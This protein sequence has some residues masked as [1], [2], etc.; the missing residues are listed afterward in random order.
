MIATDE[1]ISQVE[2]HD[3][4]I[5]M[6]ENAKEAGMTEERFKRYQ[7]IAAEAHLEA[8]RQVDL[9]IK[10]QQDRETKSWWKDEKAKTRGVVTSVIDA[11]PS[12]RASQFF[13]DGTIPPDVEDSSGILYQEGSPVKLSASALDN[14][15]GTQAAAIK[16][17][18]G[19][20]A[21]VKVGGVHPDEVAS[22][23]QFKSGDEMV[24]AMVNEP[25]R[26][27]QIAE[28]TK[29]RMVAAHGDIMKDGTIEFVSRE[30]VHDSAGH[31][32]MLQTE[33]DSMN[34]QAGQPV[35]KLSKT[36]LSGYAETQILG[37]TVRQ[38][39]PNRYLQSE[40]KAAT[41]AQRATRKGKFD[42]A[43]QWQKKRM[44]NR[45]LYSAAMEARKKAE[46]GIKFLARQNRDDARRALGLMDTVDPQ[47]NQVT[48]SYLQQQDK[49]L[50]R[51][52]LRKVSA[53]TVK[54]RQSLAEWIQR[55]TEANRDPVVPQNLLD[56][57]QRMNYADM[58]LADFLDLVDTVKNIKKQSDRKRRLKVGAEEVMFDA[59]VE[60]G[61]AQ[62]AVNGGSSEPTRVSRQNRTWA[63][64][65]I[66][67]PIRG[68]D[69]ELVRLREVANQLDGDDP[70]GLFHRIL[71]HPL[72][73]A[74]V[75]E[76]EMNVKV[77]ALILKALQELSPVERAL[78][79]SMDTIKIPSI[80]DS[81][82]MS[83][84]ITVGLQSGN[85]GNEF[86]LLAG[87]Q[88]N[89]QG[90]TP[91]TVDTLSEM[92]SQL[93]EEHWDLIQKIWDA[94]ET[95]WP[96]ASALEKRMTGLDPKK[97]EAKGFSITLPDGTTK[98]Y[99]GGYYPII[100]DPLFSG[101]NLQAPVGVGG[102]LY[103]K[104]QVR[105]VTPN[106][107]L[108]DRIDN[109]ARPIS[110]RLDGMVSHITSVIHDTTHRES[111]ISAWRFMA[112]QRI[113]DAMIRHMGE[114]YYRMVLERLR[115]VAQARNQPSKFLNIMHRGTAA[116]SAS[117][118]GFKMS[119]SLQNIANFVL[120]KQAVGTVPLA[121]AMVQYAG[122]PIQMTKTIT[123]L[124]GV[125]RH[126]MQ[127]RDNELRQAYQVMLGLDT[128][129]RKRAQHEVVK[130]GYRFM[131]MTNAIS[132]FPTW[133]AAFQSASKTMTEQEAVRAAD[134][135]IISTFGGGNVKDLALVQDNEI[136]KPF[137][138]FYGFFSSV[139]N[140]T[141]RAGRISAKQWRSGQKG[142][143][144]AG[145]LEYVLWN[146]V[147]MNAMSELF[148][149]RGPDDDPEDDPKD[150]MKTWAAWS[151][152]KGASYTFAMVPFVRDIYRMA[153]SGRREASLTPLTSIATEV[154]R[155]AQAVGKAG[156]DL[157]DADEIDSEMLAELGGNIG[158]GAL[159][160]WAIYEGMP[161][162]QFNI[163]TGFLWDWLVNENSPENWSEGVHDL[164]FTKRRNK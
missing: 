144:V 38:V 14:M 111:L 74:A 163:T 127:N 160:S 43:V 100:Y 32:K 19:D 134:D 139:Y 97:V 52:E 23:F 58:K 164:L 68:L 57:S 130:M 94:L 99:R 39:D 85:V 40:R 77:T 110:L 157:W 88:T 16:R 22:A 124:S 150:R 12:V 118:M 3:Q 60:E 149:G 126:R 151:M 142:K 84:L 37:A 75:S 125:M 154:G 6:F 78:L 153:E 54:A 45:Y 103:S 145:S 79:G 50:E 107:H 64:R 26:A 71:I 162:S 83:D 36:V 108:Q 34:R 9:Q 112:D 120:A 138:M 93:G 59:F 47:T 98:A 148:S 140:M 81:V 147:V 132:E 70:N 114:E 146:I 42:E 7:E 28:E 62:I 82:L 159:K 35:V 133:L 2:N 1:Q 72:D 65:A 104:D 129:R 95:L 156:I 69:A 123:A 117:M 109:Y 128:T 17:R 61:A 5:P 136:M 31:L 10:M 20:K 121:Q 152:A 116:V 76:S 113:A 80:G 102:T 24:R 18:L 56:E 29:R 15:Y 90:V 13:R 41:E 49:L 141:R 53:P 21:V 101:R 4:Y 158:S 131:A 44:I 122:S 89:R 92:K 63:E 11:K 91:W 25:T 67:D 8:Y 135:V 137:T 143:A 105:A 51:F 115:R 33:L 27:R 155:T 48:H 96:E 106:G 119:V 55:E 46:S 161:V 66:F 87:W 30:A 86:K 73:D